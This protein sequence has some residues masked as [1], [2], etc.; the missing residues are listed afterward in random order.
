MRAPRCN[1]LHPIFECL[2]HLHVLAAQLLTPRL[3]ACARKVTARQLLRGQRI[4]ANAGLRPE[5]RRESRSEPFRGARTETRPPAHLQVLIRSPVRVALGV[6]VRLLVAAHDRRHDLRREGQ[7]CGAKVIDDVHGRSARTSF[8]FSRSSGDIL[9]PAF[10]T[11]F[12][13]V[14]ARS[15]T[16]CSSRESEAT[17]VL[18]HRARCHDH[19]RRTSSS[20]SSSMRTVTSMRMRSRESFDRPLESRASHSYASR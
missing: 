14:M 16:A 19:P 10:S 13:C 5:R 20:L 8:L 6:L 7:A 11:S 2:P 9:A 17:T 4:D 1:D 15:L 12:L 3:D 18:L